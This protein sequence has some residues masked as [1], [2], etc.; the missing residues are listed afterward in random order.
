MVLGISGKVASGKSAALKILSK[1]GFLV[2]DADD[3][4]HDLYKKGAKGQKLIEENFGTEYLLDNGD[5]NRE[6]LGELVFLNQEKL[7]EL[8][9]LIHPL[10]YI[11]IEK[12]IEQAKVQNKN[13]AI[14][15][16]DFDEKYL[17][18]LVDKILLIERPPEQIMATMIDE[19]GCNQDIA[20]KI[21]SVFKMP[22]RVDFLIENNGSLN[23]FEK[24]L[25]KSF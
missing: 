25:L 22:N 1:H 13:L 4:V 16:I 12:A 6:L 20:T 2:L 7:I 10:V 3:I 23:D 11:L 19:R 17:G 14:E 21:I 18:K 15:A 24:E 8:N 9:E 5:V